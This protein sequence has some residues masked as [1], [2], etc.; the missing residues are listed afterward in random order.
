M[1]IYINRIAY[2]MPIS[3]SCPTKRLVKKIE[4]NW[5]VNSVIQLGA[6]CWGAEPNN[7]TF[8]VV[9]KERG[10]VVNEKVMMSD[11]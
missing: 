10:R 9:E 5:R 11:H 4:P 7:P 6:H 2:G 3:L 8:S 1:Y